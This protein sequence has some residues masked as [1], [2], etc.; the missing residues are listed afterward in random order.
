MGATDPVA[1]EPTPELATP[2]PPTAGP[3]TAEPATPAP[4]TA[5]STA[6]P[7]DGQRPGEHGET[8]TAADE[9][10]DAANSAPTIDHTPPSR[11]VRGKAIVIDLTVTPPGSYQ[12][13]LFYRATPDGAWSTTS[14]TGNGRD[15]LRLSIPREVAQE[16]SA[17]GVDYYIEVVGGGTTIRSGSEGAPFH[18]RV[19]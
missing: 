5:E 13:V 8:T 17:D 3:S 1:P 14:V 6:S 7:A 2:A 11:G 15:M 4:V 12:A 19:R 18:I 16:P 9:V 10:P